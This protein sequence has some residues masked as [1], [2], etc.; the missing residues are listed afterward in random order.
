MSIYGDIRAA[1]ESQVSSVSGIP[2]AANRA[3]Q[4]VRFEPTTGTT[5]VRMTL[6]P[7]RRRPQDVTATGLQR[8][9]GLFLVDVFAPEANGPAAAETLADAVVDSFE[10]GTVLSSGGQTI[11][12]EWAEISTS[13]VAD[14][15]WFQVPI[16]IK[17]KAFN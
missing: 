16:T 12:I 5:W 13:A 17:W 14:S 9:D 11:E 15:P 8:Y 2:S 3:W 4:N 1:L 10:A 7:S 6:N